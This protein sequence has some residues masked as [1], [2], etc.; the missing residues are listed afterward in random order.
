MKLNENHYDPRN[1]DQSSSYYDSEGKVENKIWG[2]GVQLELTEF[3]V[4]KDCE[5]NEDPK[6]LLK[7][8]DIIV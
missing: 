5:D 6:E 1:S 8:N 2:Q 4:V 3:R 7:L